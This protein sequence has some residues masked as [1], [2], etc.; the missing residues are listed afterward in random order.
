MSFLVAVKLELYVDNQE[1]AHLYCAHEM[2]GRYRTHCYSLQYCCPNLPTPK[3]RQGR[4][5]HDWNAQYLPL[6]NP[7]SCV[8]QSDALRERMSPQADPVAVHRVRHKY[9]YCPHTNALSKAARASPQSIGF[10]LNL[11]NISERA[12]RRHI[13]LPVSR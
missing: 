13:I 1:R 3:C 11:I 4:R 7:V 9:G 12:G 2:A 5:V 8:K 10:P 6:G